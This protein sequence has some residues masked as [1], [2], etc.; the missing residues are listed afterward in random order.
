VSANDP[1]FVPSSEGEVMRLVIEN[2]LAW[3]V[4]FAERDYCATPLPLRPVLDA[5]QRIT[6]LQGH[7]ARSNRHVELLRRDPRAVLLFMGPHG[8]VS[9]SWMTDRTQAPTWNYATVQFLVDIELIDEAAELDAVVRDLIGAMEA[10]RPRA[11]SADDMGARYRSLSRGIIGF[12]A[13]I[14]SRR[15]KFKLGQDERED[16]YAD[17]VGGLEANGMDELREWMRRSN[18]S[19]RAP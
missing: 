16:V 1:K 5:G 12:R 9:P 11:W 7:F 13:R 3:V 17:I 14:V 4:S 10:G 19:R 15:A 8:Y 6:G 18:P 2:P